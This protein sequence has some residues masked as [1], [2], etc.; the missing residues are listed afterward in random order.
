MDKN[1]E[2]TLILNEVE[3]DVEKANSQSDLIEA[4]D[5]VSR[6]LKSGKDLKYELGGYI[7]G[8]I[9][10]LGVSV[11]FGYKY[12]NDE[13]L[14][15]QLGWY[16]Y[17]ILCIL[18]LITIILGGVASTYSNRSDSLSDMIFNKDILFDNQL[19]YVKIR[20][21]QYETFKNQ[22]GDFKRGDEG[23]EI[24]QLIKSIVVIDDKSYD[25]YHYTFEYVE[26]TR[27]PVPV[28]KTITM[29]RKKTTYYRYG[30]ILDFPWAKGLIIKDSS[31]G[32]CPYEHTVTSSSETFNVI[33]DVAADS[34]QD[35]ARFLK[36]AVILAL[37][38]AA[39]Y[40]DELSIEI[41]SESKMCISFEDSDLL[42]FSRKYS[43]NEPE[44]FI[45]EVSLKNR[46]IKLQK[47]FEL[48]GILKQH[49]D[50]NF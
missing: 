18:L 31:G 28:G 16:G 3:S 2:I 21:D 29:Q 14:F 50:R 32:D 39:E 19:V 8:V 25:Y 6:F 22:F 37:N 11:V 7:L 45:E 23:Q 49:N 30:I 9:A 5:K 27:V 43:I 36:P 42:S 12:F 17:T 4:I 24:T 38:G 34:V 1:K 10:L 41:N 33:Y 48:V 13:K 44:K 47:A 26:V 35:A 15:N 20:N 40:F 46:P